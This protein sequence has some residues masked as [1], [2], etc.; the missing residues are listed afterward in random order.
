MATTTPNISYDE[1]CSTAMNGQ[2]KTTV[3]CPVLRKRYRDDFMLLVDVR[4]SGIELTAASRI[5]L[6][7][8]SGSASSAGVCH[9]AQ[10][11]LL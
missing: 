5:L 8:V 9:V 11:A 3:S 7:S 6:A 1:S 2:P 4:Q 10:Y